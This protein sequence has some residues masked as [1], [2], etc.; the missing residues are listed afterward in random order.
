MKAKHTPGPWKAHLHDPELGHYY[1]ADI[2]GRDSNHPAD[3]SMIRTV[4]VVLDY[5][6]DGENEANVRLIAAA[7]EL[8]SCLK[9]MVEYYRHGE[10][11]AEAVAKIQDS[12]ETIVQAE[13]K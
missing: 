4:A 5:A 2:E 13:G 1:A 10:I 11:R 12:I 3:N 8:L 6:E 9:R 7:P